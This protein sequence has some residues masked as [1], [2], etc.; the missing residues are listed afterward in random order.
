[1]EI[2][3]LFDNRRLDH[4]FLIGWGV[5]Y[6]VDG[7]ILFDTGER[8]GALFH[9]MVRM[10]ASVKDIESVVISH[11]HFDHTGGLWALLGERPGLDVYLC[12][13][14]SKEFKDEIAS[15]PCNAMEVGA[16]TAITKG[17]YS[18]GQFPEPPG[19]NGIPEQALVLSTDPGLTIVTG[20]AHAGIIDIVERV[21]TITGEKIYL[22][23]GGFHLLD[24][25]GNKVRAIDRRL[26]ELG[27]ERVGPAHCTGE[28]PTRLLKQSYGED[29]IDIRVGK[30]IKV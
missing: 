25:P 14:F 4:T 17:I 3:I 27:V 15:Y 16:L 7:H 5:S 28:E 2:K 8:A 21:K 10:G 1:M 29:F 26:R 20:C 24:Q 23:M 6:L 22:V 30:T 18:T 12:P 9:N 13:D 11:E 19:S